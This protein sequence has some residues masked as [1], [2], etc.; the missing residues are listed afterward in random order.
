MTRAATRSLPRSGTPWRTAPGRLVV[1]G[2]TTLPAWVIDCARSAGLRAELGPTGVHEQLPVRCADGTALATIAALGRD[3]MVLLMPSTPAEAPQRMVAGVRDHRTDAPVLR[4]AGD[5]ARCLNARL[6]LVHAVPLSFGE[7]SVG[8]SEALGRGTEAMSRAEERLAI[9]CPA[10][11]VRS[12]LARAWPHEAFGADLDTDLLVLGGPADGGRLG[13]V[14]SSALQH[15]ACPVLLVP[16]RLA[17][18]P[19]VHEEEG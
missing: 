3:A 19:A 1:L 15:A 13:L 14:A 4:T 10:G 17:D 16:R 7:H 11:L 5:F 9:R 8:L 6:E 18:G 12:R 2:T